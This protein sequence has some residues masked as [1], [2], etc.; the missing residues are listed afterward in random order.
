ML[1]AKESATVLVYD[2]LNEKLAMDCCRIFSL[3]QHLPHS[4]HKHS[5]EHLHQCFHIYRPGGQPVV[6]GEGEHTKPGTRYKLGEAIII[7]IVYWDGQDTEHKSDNIDQL[8]SL[9]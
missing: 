5:Q 9:G 3:S 7:I 8:A 2:K 6:A 4:Q 1:S